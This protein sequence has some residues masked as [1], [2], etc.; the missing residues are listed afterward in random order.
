MGTANDRPARARAVIHRRILDVAESNP[1]ASLSA[2]AE[3]VSG[4]SPDLVERVLDEYGDPAT[5]E[6]APPEPTSEPAT[7]AGGDESDGGK[8]TETTTEAMTDAD[9]SAEASSPGANGEAPEPEPAE[10]TPKQRRTLELI[11]DRPEASQADLAAELDV[12]RGTVSRWLNEIPGFSWP[13][14]KTFVEERLEAKETDPDGT[15]PELRRRLADVEAR[16]GGLEDERGGDRAT[17]ADE[18]PADLA[19]RVVHACMESDRVD[20]DEEL[21]VIAALLGGD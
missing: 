15:D 7:P 4:A 9:H 11:R 2:V 18:L 3:A 14:R 1:E 12:S 5:A 21:A 20:E 16:L 13:D 10:L 17:D 6:S 8:D 19:R